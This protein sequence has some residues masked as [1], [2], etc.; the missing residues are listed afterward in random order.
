MEPRL[1][2]AQFNWVFAVKVGKGT[3]LNA[4]GVPHITS[5]FHFHIPAIAVT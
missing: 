2:W 3:G 5:L 4:L 1:G